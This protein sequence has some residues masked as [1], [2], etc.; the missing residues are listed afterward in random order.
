QFGVTRFGAFVQ[1][2]WHPT[3]QLTLNLGLRYDVAKTPSQFRTDG[4]NVGPRLGFAWSP[5]TAWVVRGAFG[6][7]YDRLPLAFLNDAIQKN[8]AAA[9]EQIAY[10]ATASAIFNANGGGRVAVPL[11][12]IAPSIYKAASPFHTPHSV[13][14]SVGV[15]RLIAADTTL[16]AEFLFTRGI[17]LPRTRNVNLLPPVFLTAAN[18][19]SLGFAN[20][21]P[22]EIGRPVFGPGRSDPRFD[23]IFQLENSS[24]SNYRG[25]SLSVNRRFSKEVV[26]LASYTLAKAADDASDFFEQP[27]NP[28]NI[29]AER[30]RS[31]LDVRHRLVLSGVFDLPFGDEEDK[32]KAKSKDSLIDAVLSNIEV[33]PIITLSSGRPTNPLT[34]L[35]DEHNGAFPVNSRPLGFARNVLTTP[36]SF[37]TDIRIVKYIPIREGSKLDFAFEFFNLFNHPTAASLNPYYGSNLTPLL[38]FHSATLFGAPRQFRFSLDLEF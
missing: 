19:A 34:G 15:E 26:A 29:A 27:T 28:F 11:T 9:F 20:P 33:A 32:T 30:S 37:N 38:S 16:K 10:D 8:G 23:G 6:L 3:Q 36:R 24:R 31:L 22:Q 13:Q 4:N 35:D 18:A 14:A 17:D 1:D 2:R 12:G 25:L 21:T 7:F 5:S